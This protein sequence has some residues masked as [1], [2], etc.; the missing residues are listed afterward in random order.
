[1]IFQESVFAEQYHL[2][3]PGALRSGSCIGKHVPVMEYSSAADACSFLIMHFEEVWNMSKDI[4]EDV[5]NPAVNKAQNMR[6]RV[7]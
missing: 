6:E 1:M 5:L 4:T 2:G 7:T 3:R